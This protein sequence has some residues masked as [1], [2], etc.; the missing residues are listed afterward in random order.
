MKRRGR[1]KLVRYGCV[2]FVCCFAFCTFTAFFLLLLPEYIIRRRSA[3]SLVLR[4]IYI[5]HDVEGIKGRE[6]G[7]GGIRLEGVIAAGIL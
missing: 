4:S 1:G 5:M 7:G 2:R 6:G 3:R